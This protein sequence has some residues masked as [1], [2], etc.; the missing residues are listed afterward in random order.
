[1]KITKE[2]KELLKELKNHPW[3]KI[4]E[5]IEDEAIN[6]LW[7]FLLNS[8]LNNEKDIEVIKK[9]QIY[10]KARRDFMKNIDNHLKEIYTPNV[11]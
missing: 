9:N 4:L 11:S 3:F 7:K 8:D 5:K 1:M 2:E 6:N 10:V